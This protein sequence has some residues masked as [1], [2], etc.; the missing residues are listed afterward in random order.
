M[1]KVY[2]ARK[3][4]EESNILVVRNSKLMRPTTSCL[5]EQPGHLF[6]KNHRKTFWPSPF[7]HQPANLWFLAMNQYITNG[8]VG[9][10]FTDTPMTNI[11]WEQS[12]KTETFD[13]RTEGTPEAL[14]GQ[15]QTI[16]RA[17]GPPDR[18]LIQFKSK[19]SKRNNKK[20]LELFI[21]W[22]RWVAGLF[23]ISLVSLIAF[24]RTFL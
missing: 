21:F 18:W 6:W 23:G 17:T 16:P 14:H 9:M 8:I 4:A 7:L 3:S 20:H 22:V 5:P 13:S 1:R 24:L 11:F 2:L 12:L 10:S 19:L 15:I